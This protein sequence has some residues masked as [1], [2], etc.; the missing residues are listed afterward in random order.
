MKPETLTRTL[1]KVRH[2]KALARTNVG[3]VPSRKV[4]VDKK[5]K[6][7]KYPQKYDEDFSLKP[8]SAVDA[9]KRKVNEP[10]ANRTGTPFGGYSFDKKADT[11]KVKRSGVSK[12]AFK[13]AVKSSKLANH[14]DSAAR[15]TADLHKSAYKKTLRDKGIK[16]E[17]TVIKDPLA[18]RDEKWF[19][20]KGKESKKN[21][22]EINKTRQGYGDYA[23]TPFDE[24]LM[25]FLKKGKKKEER[26]HPT[27][28]DRYHDVYDHEL[29][30]FK[31]EWQKYSSKKKDDGVKKESAPPGFEG[32]VK[33]MKKHKDTSNPFALAWSMKKGLQEPC[34][35]S[36][37]TC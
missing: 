10:D 27:Q 37:N 6:K 9:A 21:T 14:P 25:D 35:G 17:E 20:Q 18:P 26:P 16:T 15:Y 36:H 19:K 7:P 2:V 13:T 22:D 1:D 24:G 23:G 33:A 4:F 28:Y 31:P 30:E 11:E 34:E 29:P 32:T 5:S 8:K 12:G 3:T